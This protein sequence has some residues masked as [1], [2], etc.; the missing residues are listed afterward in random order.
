MR[1]DLCEF[2]DRRICEQRENFRPTLRRATWIGLSILL[3]EVAQD[4]GDATVAEH[5][6]AFSSAMLVRQ[7]GHVVPGIQEP[8]ADAEP[9]PVLSDDFG[10]YDDA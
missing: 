3:E 8:F 4:L 1:H 6:R 9:A 7:K 2:C 10:A 5:E